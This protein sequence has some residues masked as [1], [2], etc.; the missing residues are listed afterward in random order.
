MTPFRAGDL[1][2]V[3]SLDL[4]PTDQT[5]ASQ[6]S[7][8]FVALGQ[9]FEVEGRRQKSLEALRKA[10][11]LAPSPDL[12]RVI[13]ELSRPAGVVLPGDTLGGSPPR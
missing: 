10:Y 11:H 7:I 9:G 12:N 3:D 13:E 4:D 1:V 6:L 2:A 8:P 5:I